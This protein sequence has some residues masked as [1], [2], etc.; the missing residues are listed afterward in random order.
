MRSARAEA[1]AIIDNARRVSN[2]VSEELKQLR[3]QKSESS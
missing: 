1:Q 3:K 2:E